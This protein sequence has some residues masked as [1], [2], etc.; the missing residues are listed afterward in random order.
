MNVNSDFCPTIEIFALGFDRFSRQS[1]DKSQRNV[2]RGLQLIGKTINS[3]D[4]LL[5][6]QQKVMK[7]PDAKEL[8][9]F[10]LVLI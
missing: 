4:I 2:S 10:L 1:R 8:L 6:F 7:K 3:F 5:I 9:L